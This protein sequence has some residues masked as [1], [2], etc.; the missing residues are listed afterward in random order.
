MAALVGLHAALSP[1]V[2]ASEQAVAHQQPVVPVGV[3]IVQVDAVVT[4]RDGRQVTNLTA[5]DF[6]IREEGRRQPITH[7]QYVDL[8]HPAEPAPVATAPDPRTPPAAT[9]ALA[10]VIDDLSLSLDG[11]V[12][13]RH[14]LR[15]LVD[16][17]VAPQD[18]V[19][20]VRTSRGIDNLPPFTSEKRLLKAA[21]RGVPLTLRAGGDGSMSHA[22]QAG[23]GPA[24]VATF[25]ERLRQ[26]GDPL[27]KQRQF[28]LTMATLSVLDGVIRALGQAPGRKALLLVSDG[29]VSQDMHGDTSTVR[30][31]VERV[32][33]DANQAQVVI[34]AVGPAPSRVIDRAPNR[35]LGRQ[36]RNCDSSLSIFQIWSETC[37][38]VRR[39]CRG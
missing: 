6:E 17:S 34:Y 5:N 28:H 13:A 33:D 30:S 9:R 35:C 19:S 22:V 38:Q 29:F 24:G 7:F 31:R 16:Q 32:A 4:D 15:D 1:L 25:T 36:P 2:P 37:A 3:E 23:P 12:H 8:R 21:I 11:L 10:I 20:V 27:E 14:A 18:L 26:L 39:S